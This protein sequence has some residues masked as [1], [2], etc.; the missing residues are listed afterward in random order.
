MIDY[1]TTVILLHKRSVNDILA[2]EEFKQWSHM[3]CI[4]TF[5]INHIFVRVSSNITIFYTNVLYNPIDLTGILGYH[6]FATLRN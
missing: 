3:S 5:P 6:G 4:S 1:V 2:S